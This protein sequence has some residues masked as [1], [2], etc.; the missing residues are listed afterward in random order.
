MINM[1]IDSGFSEESLR[2]IAR[3]KVNFRFS[4]KIHVGA[5][6]VVSMI[7]LVVNLILSPKILWIIYPF[8]GWLIGVLIHSVAYIV[9]AR[10]IFPIAKRGVIFHIV[11]YIS[12]IFLLF[13][14]NFLTMPIYPWILYPTTFWGLALIIH[15]ILYFVFYRGKIDEKGKIK[16]RKERAIEKEM[17][18]MRKKMKL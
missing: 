2:E 5:F 3:A 8:F 11:A 10:G 15:F 7:L 6:I 13:L 12:V 18:K 14:I 4:V 17:E 16:L 9:Y 1:S